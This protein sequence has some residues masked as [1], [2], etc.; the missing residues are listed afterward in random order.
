[1]GERE[2]LIFSHWPLKVEVYERFWLLFTIQIVAEGSVGSTLE[3]TA[4]K[5]CCNFQ[6][7]VLAGSL[8]LNISKQWRHKVILSP[9]CLP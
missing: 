9:D 1:M 2:V 4:S 7:Q 3:R 6:T 5:R 8:V